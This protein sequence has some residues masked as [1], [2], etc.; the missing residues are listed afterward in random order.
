MRFCT[1]KITLDIHNSFIAKEKWPSEL[2]FYFLRI[3]FHT[4][5]K[6]IVIWVGW[7]QFYHFVGFFSL[8]ESIEMRFIVVFVCSFLC[9]IL[10]LCSFFYVSY[11]KYTKQF[12]ELYTKLYAKQFE[13]ISHA[14]PIDDH[15]FENLNWS[16]PCRRFITELNLI[17]IK[18]IN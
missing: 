13:E 18:Q 11:T 8:V 1:S 10:T 14:A 7:A 15:Y 17:I 9:S 16:F 4:T 12:E 3:F 5:I 6:I 2:C